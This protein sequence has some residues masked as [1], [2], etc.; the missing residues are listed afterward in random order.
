MFLQQLYVMI[1]YSFVYLN[2]CKEEQNHIQ[3]LKKVFV[4]Y[5]K[6]HNI[7]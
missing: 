1:M 2:L 4:H 7:F 5:L 6:V 3:W